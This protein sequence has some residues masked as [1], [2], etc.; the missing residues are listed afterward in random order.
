MTK[1]LNY[2]NQIVWS[3]NPVRCR[4]KTDNDPNLEDVR[5]NVL[6]GDVCSI[7]KT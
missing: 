4:L 5:E 6:D 7:I 2:L 1:T 3:R